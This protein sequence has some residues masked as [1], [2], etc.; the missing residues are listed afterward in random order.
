MRTLKIAAL[1]V[2]AGAATL[3]L[4]AAMQPDPFHIKRSTHI[5]AA[6]SQVFAQIN[7]LKRM[8]TWN[9]YERKDPA[10]V[11]E[12]GPTMEGKGASYTWISEKVGV[13]LMTIVATEPATKVSLQL[14]FVKPF[15]SQLAVDYILR[16]DGNGTKVTWAM[17]GPSNVVHKV[18]QAM[19]VLDPLV[20]RDLEA[21]LANLKVQ[22]ETQ[23]IAFSARWEA[24]P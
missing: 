11:G 3:A 7:D 1:V 14:D 4:A 15:E 17:K 23:S 6:P 19:H 2:L 5:D 13:G 16:A 12:F 20:G 24:V 10:L 22:A 9:P 21:G 8:K 18:M